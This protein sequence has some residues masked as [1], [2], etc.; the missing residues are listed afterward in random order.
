MLGDKTVPQARDQSI[1]ES[2]QRPFHPRSNF[3]VDKFA[4]IQNSVRIERLFEPA[5]KVTSDIAR[6]FRPP[7]FLCQADSVFACDHAAPREHLRKKIVERT[8]DLF[9]DSRVAI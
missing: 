7:A 1:E 6:R 5:M 4:G 2:P 8:L 9:A 3:I